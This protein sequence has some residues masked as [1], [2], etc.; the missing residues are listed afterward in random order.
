MGRP[1][2]L[3]LILS[4]V[5]VAL[6][7]SA[8]AAVP[9][10]AACAA[11][12]ARISLGGMH[13]ADQPRPFFLGDEGSATRVTIRFSGGCGATMFVDYATSP[14]S[15]QSSDYGHTAD[16]VSA[17]VPGDD[18]AEVVSLVSIAGGDSPDTAVESVQ[19]SLSN[20]RAVGGSAGTPTLFNSSFP[21]L[22][23]DEQGGTR[24]S[25]EGVPYGQ[26]ESFP[27]ARI[28]VFRAGTV[29]TTATVN[30]TIEPDPSAP[31]TPGQDFSGPSSGTITFTDDERV[32]TI[33]LS[34]TNDTLGE[35]PESVLVTLSS[36][37]T[38]TI[39]NAQTTFTIQDNEESERPSSRFHHPRHK[40]RYK[41]SDYRIREFHVFANDNPGGAGVVGAEMALKRTRMNGKCQWFTGKDW[42]AKDCQNREW[43]DMK[44]DSVGQLFLYRM[45]QL[46]SSVGT[47]IK[48]YTAFS[49]A[50]DG[51]G[52]VENDFKEKRNANT[53]EIKRTRRRR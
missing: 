15:A 24:V 45:K 19:F 9:A 50:I 1:M 21:I 28:P 27:F 46:K 20:P 17:T 10:K 16:T 31:A 43:V 29:G 41:K 25:F 33:D 23:V 5:A 3:R 53:F 35:G 26:S 4:V 38:G 47:K 2:K 12:P 8:L 32:K 48:N 22:I 18:T 37:S 52:N 30:Y 7:S 14:G 13:V 40:W 11:A 42:Q 36:P 49:R 51:S 34:V 39:E 6:A 44:Y